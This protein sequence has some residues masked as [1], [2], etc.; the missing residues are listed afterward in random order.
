[1]GRL[2]REELSPFRIPLSD[3]FAQPSSQCRLLLSEA[4]DSVTRPACDELLDECLQ[5]VR[6]L[7][8]Q[9]SMR[10]ADQPKW[11]L[12][13]GD[14][15]VV[16]NLANVGSASESRWIGARGSVML[17]TYLNALSDLNL[18]D[19]QLEVGR[20]LVIRKLRV[21]QTGGVLGKGLAKTEEPQ[22]HAA[23][24]LLDGVNCGSPYPMARFRC[25][26]K[27][28]KSCANARGHVTLQCVD[29]ALLDDGRGAIE[30]TEQQERG[31]L[32]ISNTASRLRRPGAHPRRQG[33]VHNELLEALR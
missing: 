14:G 12:S 6:I 32:R 13:F 23:S 28:L 2:A 7:E 17:E 11:R 4:R 3:A 20:R 21:V 5:R 29:K 31:K 1:L 15:A 9:D 25:R 19:G 33:F 22:K 18:I 27:C 24:S 8:S 16:T 30:E 26:G 10:R